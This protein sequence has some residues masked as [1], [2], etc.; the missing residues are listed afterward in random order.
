[1]QDTI[2]KELSDIHVPAWPKVNR[3]SLMLKRHM[4]WCSLLTVFRCQNW[5]WVI[6]K[7]TNTHLRCLRFDNKLTRRQHIKYISGALYQCGLTL[8]L[9]WISNYIHHNVWD[10]IAYPF[11]NFNRGS[12]GVWKWISNFTQHFIRSVITYPYWDYS[13]T[14]IVEGAPGNIQEVRASSSKPKIFLTSR[15][16]FYFYLSVLHV[17]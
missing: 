6:L 12:V 7:T 10:D 4:Q 1:M 9:A 3:L 11:P 8:I 13:E 14:L 16:H 5:N 17:L 2:N 15:S